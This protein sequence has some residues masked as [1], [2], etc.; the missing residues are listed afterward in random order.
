MSDFKL[1]RPG[2]YVSHETWYA[3]SRPSEDP[4]IMIGDYPAGGGTPG[5]FAIRWHDLGDYRAARLE[6]YHDSWEVFAEMCRRFKLPDRLEVLADDPSV[7]A[8]AALL[9]ELGF[10][11]LTER[12]SPHADHGQGVRQRALAKLTEEERQALGVVP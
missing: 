11:D 9:A 7:E 5:E 10:T 8:V 12:E 1:E 6:V 2:F 4:G 3:G